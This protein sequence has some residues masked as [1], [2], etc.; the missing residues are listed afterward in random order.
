MKRKRIDNYCLHGHDLTKHGKRIGKKQEVYCRACRRDA[1]KRW[2]LKKYAEDPQWQI[3]KHLRL[4][5][6]ITPEHKQLMLLKQN[7]SCAICKNTDFGM[8]G[9]VI[10]HCHKTGKIRGILCQKCNR[11]LGLFNDNITALSNAIEYLQKI[12]R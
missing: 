7:N 1:N 10:D 4:N 5:Y 3:R 6:G 12:D 9:P 2:H 8:K 11:A